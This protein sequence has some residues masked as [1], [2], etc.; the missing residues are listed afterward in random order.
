MSAM[1][2]ACL[3]ASLPALAVVPM[4]MDGLDER[5][6]S[7]LDI[8]C[9]H[10]GD[11]WWLAA[12]RCTACGQHWMVA[13]EERIFDDFFMR[14]LDDAE[15]ECVRSGRWPDDFL[16]Y[17]RVLAIGNALSNPCRFADPLA[18]ALVW[19]ADDLKKARPEVTVEE[20]AALLGVTPVHARRLLDAAARQL[21]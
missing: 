5:V 11:P 6:F 9:R 1:P 2:T 12:Y 15:A 19:T 14:R 3:C 17:E 7:T 18:S 16:T 4:G 8:V 20:I 10:G 21:N 13:Q